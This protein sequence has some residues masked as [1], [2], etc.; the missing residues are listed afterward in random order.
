ML[1]EIGGSCDVQLRFNCNGIYRRAAAARN[2]QLGH[3]EVSVLRNDTPAQR[4]RLY[5]LRLDNRSDQAGGAESERRD[6]NSA[7]H[8]SRARSYL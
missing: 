4:D 7:Q 1:D 6:G 5:E 8:D 2:R 3:D